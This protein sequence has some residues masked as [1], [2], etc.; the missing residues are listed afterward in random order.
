MPQEF[1]YDVRTAYVDDELEYAAATYEEA[2][3]CADF[4]QDAVEG[5]ELI[6]YPSAAANVATWWMINAWYED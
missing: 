4:P 2:Q 3:A 1:L 5:R 6:G